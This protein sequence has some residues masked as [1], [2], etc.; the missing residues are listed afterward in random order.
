MKKRLLLSGSAAC[1]VVLG[2]MVA[3]AAESKAAPSP[4]KLPAPAKKTF[5]S[6]FNVDKSNLTSVGKNP[7]FIPLEPGYRLILKGDVQGSLEAIIQAL[8]RVRS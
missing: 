5:K 4:D 1:I 7:Y 8:M 2:A 6:V 3:P